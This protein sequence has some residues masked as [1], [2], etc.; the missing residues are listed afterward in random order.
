MS[1]HNENDWKKYEMQLRCTSHTCWP[2]TQTH[3]FTYFSHFL[4]LDPTVGLSRI[5]SCQQVGS[6]KSEPRSAGTTIPSCSGRQRFSFGCLNRFPHKIQRSLTFGAAM[7][8]HHF[9]IHS[10]CQPRCWLCSSGTP[11]VMQGEGCGNCR[12]WIHPFCARLLPDT[13]KPLSLSPQDDEN[14]S[15]FGL[16]PFA[17]RSPWTCLLPQRHVL[18]RKGT[19]AFSPL[20]SCTLMLPSLLGRQ[21]AN[22]SSPLHRIHAAHPKSRRRWCAAQLPNTTV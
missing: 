1:H 5:D 16:P 11:S 22:L 4:G 12:R 7:S 9:Q 17:L 18:G 3:K 10:Q 2:E 20:L 19:P 6:G 8:L 21:G 15:W 14:N 13:P